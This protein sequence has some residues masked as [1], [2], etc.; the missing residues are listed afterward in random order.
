MA[1]CKI[2]D[3]FREE[4]IFISETEINDEFVI[5]VVEDINHKLNL[6]LE[7]QGSLLTK[8]SD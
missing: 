4:N 2:T 3:F 1:Q 8:F 7:N 6:L 5:T